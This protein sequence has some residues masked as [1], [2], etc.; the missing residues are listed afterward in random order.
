[1]SAGRDSG[2]GRE[3]VLQRWYQRLVVVL[4]VY[5]RLH[6]IR[7]VRACVVSNSRVLPPPLQ[8]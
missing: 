1:M 6:V 4:A 5:V 7:T 2:V 8:I 3:A